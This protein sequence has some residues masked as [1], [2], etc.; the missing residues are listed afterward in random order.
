MSKRS[1]VLVG[2]DPAWPVRYERERHAIAAAL[3][4]NLVEIHHIGSTAVP[5]LR[6]KPVIDV[7]LGVRR[8]QP[9][10][11]EVAAMERAGFRYLGEYGIRERCYYAKDDCHAHGFLV[12]K[13]QWAA[14]LR[15]RDYLRADAGARERYAAAKLEIA[16]R[17]GWDRAR[18]V[19][20]KEWVVAALLREAARVP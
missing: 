19:E 1:L 9:T 13:G 8:L 12:G 16:Q 2:Y 3:G 10:P 4:G 6:S 14:H 15:F 20:E 5:G 18:Y 11:E 7:L 17:V